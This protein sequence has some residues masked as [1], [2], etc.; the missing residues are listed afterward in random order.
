VPAWFTNI[1]KCPVCEELRKQ[2]DEA[3][4][5]KSRMLEY[6]LHRPSPSSSETV[7]PEGMLGRNEINRNEE[8]NPVKTPRFVPW[9]V[10]RQMLETQDRKTA[11]LLQR[12]EDE[13]KSLEK[14]LNLNQGTVESVLTNNVG[15]EDGIL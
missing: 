1:D 15:D 3:N 13:I 9:N 7:K 14:K 2:L 8:E 4:R 12:K 11:E 10:R 6:I 5:E